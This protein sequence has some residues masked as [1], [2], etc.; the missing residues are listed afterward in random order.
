MD[1][2]FDRILSDAQEDASILMELAA[3]FL[4]EI[5]SSNAA[6]IH[7]KYDQISTLFVKKRDE[8]PLSTILSE[9]CHG[10]TLFYLTKFEEAAQVLRAANA[11][12]VTGMPKDILGAIHWALGSNYRSLGEIDKATDHLLRSVRLLNK[13]GLFRITC[14]YSYY[15]L[16][17]IHVTIGE[18][19]NAQAYYNVAHDLIILSENKTANFRIK[20]GMGVCALHLKEYKKSE[21]CFNEAISIEGLSAAEK[22]RG[23]CDLGIVNIEQKRFEKALGYLEESYTLRVDNNLEDAAST[24][25]IYLAEI[26][27]H[28]E[29]FDEAIHMLEQALE[30]THKFKAQSK[31]IKVL[32]LLAIAYQNKENYKEALH[33]FNQYDRLSHEVR[34]KQEHEIFRLKNRQIEEQKLQIEKQHDQLKETLDE[35]AKVKTSRKSLFFSIGTAISLVILT[36]AFFDPLID[37]YAYNVY[38]SLAVKVLIALLLKPMD[39]FYERILLRRAMKLK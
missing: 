36:E 29:N 8:S 7:R 22:S 33:Y 10:A 27:I 24:S 18:Y 2:R 5:A 19:E 23:L 39:T 30:I 3:Y 12:F 14:A 16:G 34:T 25:L 11:H 31:E 13:E 37:S 35:L 26:R 17:E 21:S 6:S 1:S 32:Q 4:E 28:L 20:D 38:I 15:Q 9:L